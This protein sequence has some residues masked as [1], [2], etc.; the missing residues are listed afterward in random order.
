MGTMYTIRFGKQTTY[1][2]FVLETENLFERFLHL[3]SAVEHLTP[4]ESEKWNSLLAVYGECRFTDA[5]GGLYDVTYSPEARTFYII[6]VPA[7]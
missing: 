2:F 4:C 3:M 1:D 6:T 7:R 5:D